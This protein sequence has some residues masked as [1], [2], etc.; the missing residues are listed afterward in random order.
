MRTV[1]F[2]L[3]HR[4]LAST[5]SPSY[6]L[7]DRFYLHLT[8]LRELGLWDEA[9]TLLDTDLAKAICD[10]SLIC[11]EVRREIWANK[12]MQKQEGEKARRQIS[13]KGCVRQMYSS[14]QLNERDALGIET[15][16]NSWL[17]SMLHL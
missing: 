9:Y 10:T 13:E 17:L 14:D 3:S 1:L 2:R 7:A 8:V 6:I 15:G 11:D 5:V 4:L 16:W 12:G